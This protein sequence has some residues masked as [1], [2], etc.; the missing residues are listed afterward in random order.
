MLLLNLD[1]VD[2]YARYMYRLHEHST[3][4]RY[5]W[6]VK[7]AVSFLTASFNGTPPPVD[8]IGKEHLFAYLTGTD[9]QINEPARATWNNQLRP[10]RSFWNYLR[11]AEL[12]DE[13]PA[14]KIK[15][16]TID[17]DPRLPITFAEFLDMLEAIDRSP[18]L[19]RTRNRAILM[20]LF[21]CG[22]RVS[23]VRRLRLTHIDWKNSVFV[24]LRVKGG[25]SIDVHFPKRVA[26]A[27]KMWLANR[28]RFRPAAEEDACFVSDR[29]TQISVRQL[30][31]IIADLGK[32][33]RIHRP[34]SPHVVRHTSATELARL[35]LSLFGLKEFLAHESIE[36]TQ[37]YVHLTDEIKK[38]VNRLAKRFA[39]MQAKRR[40]L[41]ARRA[42][43]SPS[44][45]F[46]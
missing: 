16:A 41:R 19:Y 45:N 38:A 37:R 1:L 30:Q 29:S 8:A 34:V 24:N 10:L 36:A 3:A 42:A 17:S 2:S 40:K 27:L 12:T 26:K 4:K 46:A 15:P 18:R 6:E 22:L 14:E 39:A 11:E 32:E 13:N 44:P 31:G 35:G 33:A 9:E 5:V 43:L 7:K 23:E 25:R 20:V 21:F 28:A